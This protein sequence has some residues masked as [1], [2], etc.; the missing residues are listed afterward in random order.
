MGWEKGWA[1]PRDLR[2]AAGRMEGGKGMWAGKRISKK[3]YSE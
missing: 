2:T 3:G 1:G